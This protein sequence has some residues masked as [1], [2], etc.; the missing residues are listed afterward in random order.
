MTNATF[1]NHPT[2]P[3]KFKDPI[4]VYYP[5]NFRIWTTVPY[6]AGQRPSKSDIQKGEKD[7]TNYFAEAE[8]K[9]MES[10]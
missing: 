2:D 7:Y 1:E 9:L 10:E 6:L 8:K 5:D 3:D 4:D